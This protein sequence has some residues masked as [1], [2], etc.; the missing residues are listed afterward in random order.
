MPEFKKELKKELNLKVNLLEKKLPIIPNRPPFLKSRNCPPVACPAIAIPEECR[1]DVYF[2]HEGSRCKG[3]DRDICTDNTGINPTVAP[4]NINRPP[5]RPPTDISPRRRDQPELRPI[6]ISPFDPRGPRQAFDSTRGIPIDNMGPWE[7]RNF[8]QRRRWRA[9][10]G[11]DSSSLVQR[12]RTEFPIFEQSQGRSGPT[13]QW[14]S[15]AVGWQDVQGQQWN[16]QLLPGRGD[17]SGI[18]PFSRDGFPRRFEAGLDP[19]ILNI[20]VSPF[21][22]GQNGI[23]SQINGQQFAGNTQ[24]R[25]DPFAVESLGSD[26]FFTR[27]R[28][29]EQ[30]QGVQFLDPT[31]PNPTLTQNI[32]SG[33]LPENRSPW[34]RNNSP[35]APNI[36]GS[37]NS[38]ATSF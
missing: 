16:E 12:P 28:N 4:V 2:R 19:S 21:S 34:L 1:E 38:W 14:Q 17:L 31:I 37:E 15:P 3:C 20:P 24:G 27:G 26:Q 29:V 32:N 6:D 33:R 5:F 22:V 25:S 11:G 23:N 36:P 10:L 35:N 13:G 8:R 18:N 9:G 7:D 30:F